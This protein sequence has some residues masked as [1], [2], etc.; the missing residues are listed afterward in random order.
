MPKLTERIRQVFSTKAAGRTELGASGTT[1]FSGIID[2]EE[3]V[4]DLKGDQLIDTVNKMR[5]SDATVKAAL[6]A[7]TLPILSADWDIEPASEDSQDIEIADVVKQNLFEDLVWEDLLREILLY[8]PFG[9]YAFE[10]VFKLVDGVFLWKKWAPRLPKTIY[11]WNMEKGEL[12]SVVQRVY[13]EGSYETITIPAEKLLIFTNEKEGD[14]FRGT[15][16]LRQAYKHWWYRKNY[17]AIDA[18]ATERHG[19][20]IPVITLPPGYSPQDKEEADEL[21]SNLRANQQSHITRPSPQWEIEMLDMKTS[22]LK[23]PQKMLEHH[24][25]EILKSVLAQFIELGQQT[26]SWALNEGQMAFF[27]DGVDAAACYTENVINKYAIQQMVDLNW[28][29]DEYPKLTHGDLGVIDVEKLSNALQSLSMVGMVTPDPEMERYLRN[30]LKLPEPPEEFGTSTPA[31]KTEELETEEEKVETEEKAKTEEKVKT[32]KKMSE[33][34]HRQLTKAEGAVRFDE[35]KRVMDSEEKVLFNE[36]SK[37]LIRERA[38]L[39]PKFERAVQNNDLAA[40][41]NIAGRFKGEYERVFRNG[42]KKLFEYGKNKAAFEI[43]KPAPSTTGEKTG[44]IFDQA[45]YYAERHYKDLVDNLKSAASM[46]VLDKTVSTSDTIKSVKDTYKKFINRNCAITANLSVAEGFNEGRKYSFDTYSEDV[47]GYQWSAILDGATCFPA[48]TKVIT[49]KGER[50]IQTIKAGDKV[51][52]RG[53]F[54]QVTDNGVRDYEGRVV[55]VSSTKGHFVC[56]EDHPV[57]VNGGFEEAKYLTVGDTLTYSRNNV[58]FKVA[59][60]VYGFLGKSQYFEPVF[61]KVLSFL[62]ILRFISVPVTA[63]NFYTNSELGDVEIDRVPTNTGFLC[64]TVRDIFK[65]ASKLLFKPAFAVKSA[66]ARNITEDLVSRRNLSKRFS[67]RF[68]FNNDRRATTLFGAI[69]P[70]LAFGMIK[71]LATSFTNAVGSVL[72]FTLQRAEIISTSIGAWYGEFFA[73]PN[74]DFNYSFTRISTSKGAEQITTR[75]N[76]VGGAIEYSTAAGTND[77]FPRLR[78]FM[79]ALSGTEPRV[80]ALV[81]GLKRFAANLASVGHQPNYNINIKNNRPLKVYNLQVADTAE[82]FANRALVHNCNYCRSMDGKVIGGTDKKF[83]SYQPGRV[84]FNCRCIWVA[85][86][87]GEEN[88]PAFTGIPNQLRPQT[89]VPP[90][91]FKDLHAPLPGSTHLEIEDRLTT[92]AMQRQ[93]EVLYGKKTYREG[94]DKND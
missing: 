62:N 20:G 53:G 70:I 8:L 57:F 27:V 85:I 55:K 3:Y 93:E 10:K 16:L 39:M 46:G 23:D 82:Y 68:T 65:G 41:Q 42:S 19:V 47:Y 30:I 78:G 36:L 86:L 76:S 45:H 77:I 72:A 81:G 88:P 44:E 21:G 73:T 74:T 2:T 7:V 56:T 5:W 80:S 64:E 18:I 15:S 9:F 26:G 83:S 1:I 12:V 31:S 4:S 29:V 43:K 67:A 71:S 50:Y 14:N 32:E 28:T 69:A 11:E 54:K 52:T 51:L 61:G 6:L 48:G 63:I 89:E 90:W 60:R 17:Y 34:W 92:P 91:G 37:I 40:L 49:D 13:K 58:F 87:K 22:T 33:R 84:H 66:V 94:A 25:R 59:D 75:F 35:I 24:T 79:V 38:Y